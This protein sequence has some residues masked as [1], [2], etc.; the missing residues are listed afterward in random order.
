MAYAQRLRAEAQ[1]RRRARCQ[2]LHEHIGACEKTVEHDCR[3]GLFQI[4]RDGFLRAIEPDEMARQPLHGRVVAATEVAGAGPL[5]LDYACTEIRQLPRG[6]WRGDR[7]LDGD[8][9][10]ALQ[11]QR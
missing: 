7:L 2:V 6:E 8:D 10:D 3:L 1:A 4:E 5:D 9:S 11:R